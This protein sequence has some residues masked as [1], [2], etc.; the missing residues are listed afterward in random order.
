MKNL[1]QITLIIIIVSATYLVFSNLVKHA[2][3]I[4]SQ[5]IEMLKGIELQYKK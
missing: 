4:E 3:N 5:N 2:T 1:K